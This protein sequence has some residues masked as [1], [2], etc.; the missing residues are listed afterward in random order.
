[1][2]HAQ[3]RNLAVS[4][5]VLLLILG[6][7]AMLIRYSRQAQRLAELQMNFVAGVSHEL[8]TPLTVIRTAAYNLRSPAFRRNEDQVERYGRMIEAE[9]GKLDGLVEQVL[10]F[11]GAQAGHAVRSRETV[12][13]AVLLDSEIASLRSAFESRGVTLE[14]NIETGLPSV[15]GDA[16]ALRHAFRNLLDNALKHG[17][18]SEKWIGVTARTADLRGHRMVEI[19]VA[20]RE[21]GVPASERR[22]IFE[23]FIRGQRALSDQIHGTGLGLNLVKTIIEA[24]AGTVEVNNRTEGGA[25]F[26]VRIPA[27]EAIA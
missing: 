27:A 24:H 22:R 10:S 13:P 11:A 15:I 17:S 16:G 9:S 1:M 4:G 3:K 12:D 7:V 23:P 5:A 25:E 6:S 18:V 26:L 14:R 20:D 2:A 8:R 21:P 19:R